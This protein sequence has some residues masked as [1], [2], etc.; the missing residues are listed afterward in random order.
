MGAVGRLEPVKGFAYFIDSAFRIAERIPSV[1]F[2]LAGDGTLSDE[3]RRQAAP[4]ED[5]FKFLGLRHDVAELMAAMDVFVLTS[6]NEGMGRVLLEAGAAGT[7]AVATRVGGV[8]DII[9]DGVTGILV[10]PREPEA[11]AEA[12][13]ALARDPVRRAA[14]GKAAREVVVPAFG[15]EQM[16]G[17]I[18]GLYEELIREKRLDG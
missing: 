14:M 10:P 8:P 16:V 7:P 4:L 6:I 17:R 2:V 11:I 3:L 1:R 5:R 13:L 15:L 18:E 12:V 9:R